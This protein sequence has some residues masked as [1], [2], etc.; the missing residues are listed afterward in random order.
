MR[1]LRLANNTETLMAT[2]PD[3]SFE[4]QRC[5]FTF[6]PFNT[7]PQSGSGGLPNAA[8]SRPVAS[9]Y[10]AFKWNK[11]GLSCGQTAPVPIN[12]SPHLVMD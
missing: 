3:L 7:Y 12:K 6:F 1:I 8:A 11:A 5:G 9:S 10:M 4:Y 2:T